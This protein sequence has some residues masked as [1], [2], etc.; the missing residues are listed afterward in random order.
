MKAEDH[1]GKRYEA[2]EGYFV[3][4]GLITSPAIILHNPITGERQTVVIGCQNH[5]E[6]IELSEKDALQ[7]LEHHV[8]TASN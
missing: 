7:N 5:K 2:I 1:L 8:I 3:A 4:V 6:M